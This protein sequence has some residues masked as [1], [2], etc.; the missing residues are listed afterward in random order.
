MKQRREMAHQ[1]EE[2]IVIYWSWRKTLV[3]VCAFLIIPFFII[4]SYTLTL[5][6]TFLNREYYKEDLKQID[7]YNR[8][9]NE[10]IPSIILEME[11]SDNALTDSLAKQ[12][13]IWIIGK[14]VDPA[15]VQDQTEKL[16]DKT[17]DYLADPDKHITLDLSGSKDFLT[18][19][20]SGLFL[21]E[22]LI[23]S[24]DQ[25]QSG[26]STS[27]LSLLKNGGLDCSKM[28][29]NLDDIRSDLSGIRQKINTLQLGVVNLDNYIGNANSF[30]ESIRGY[31]HNIRF[32]FWFSIAMLIILMAGIVLLQIGDIYFMLQSI[33][34]PLSIASLLS[35][36][37]GLLGISITP[38]DY[39]GPRLY[40][41]PDALKN[42]INDFMR[43]GIQGIHKELAVFSGILLG[44]FLLIYIAI[45]I[46][47]K[48]NFKFSK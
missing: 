32:Y 48:M 33:F 8:L 41:L 46:L 22:T 21:A 11:I 25:A 35:L 15:W 6:R 19:A 17:A 14:T 24:C 30:I 23:P 34:L 44:I 3:I 28:K 18:K 36:G 13:S 45:L 31:A 39:I 4:F 37:I 20:S 43:L 9:I 1:G 5:K 47:K 29:T 38:T 10:G 26:A 42:I 2:K 16:V 40:T 12:V 7:A 27:N